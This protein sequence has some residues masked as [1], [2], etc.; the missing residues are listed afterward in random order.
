MIPAPATIS[1]D[2]PRDDQPAD[3]QPALD[4]PPD[5]G[6]P[7]EVASGPGGAGQPMLIPVSELTGHPGNVREDLELSRQ[8]CASVAEAGVRIPLLVTAAEDGYRVIEGHRRLAAAVKAGLAAVPCVLDPGRAG[9]EAG[10]YL[11]MA[12]A[13][14]GT[15]RRNLT[16]QQEA[17]ALFA[18]SEAGASRIRIRKATGHSAADVKTALRAGGC[19]GRPG[20]WL[21]SC[22]ASRAWMSW[23]CWPSSTATPRRPPRC[24]ARSPTGIRWSTWPSGS[25]R[26]APRPPGTTSSPPS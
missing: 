3:A 22:P 8:F 14:S 15:L 2:V 9:D 6:Q 23:R 16:P 19:P 20:R 4:T 17:D 21:A 11:D 25:A 1:P 24:W 26:N 18:A 12:I 5:A 10:Q 13:N 7:A